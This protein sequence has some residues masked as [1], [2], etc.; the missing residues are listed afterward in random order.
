MRC[1]RLFFGNTLIEKEKTEFAEPYFFRR[2]K[3]FIASALSKEFLNEILV[4]TSL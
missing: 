3:V 4:K 2:D 1:T